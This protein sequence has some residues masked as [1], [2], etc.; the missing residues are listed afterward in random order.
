[1]I[2]WFVGWYAV[3]GIGIR[4]RKDFLLRNA[5]FAAQSAPED[6]GNV[7]TAVVCPVVSIS[8]SCKIH[9]PVQ[10][11]QYVKEKFHERCTPDRLLHFC[12]S[13]VYCMKGPL[14]AS[15]N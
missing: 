8:T 12:S 1:M 15:F 9:A 2:I 5:S 3:I 11:W 14:N 7:V 6:N 10:Q 4:Q 13:V